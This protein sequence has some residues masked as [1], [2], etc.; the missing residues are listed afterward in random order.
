MQQVDKPSFMMNYL[1]PS[2]SSEQREMAKYIIGHLF[3]NRKIE[4]L[5]AK[6]YDDFF[7]YHQ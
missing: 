2:F 5:R 4:F 7:P 3:N 1:S 6:T